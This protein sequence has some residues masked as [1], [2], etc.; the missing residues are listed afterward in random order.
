MGPVAASAAPNIW[1]RKWLITRVAILKTEP[2]MPSPRV[3]GRDDFSV[4]LGTRRSLRRGRRC[5]A[6]E[7]GEEARARLRQMQVARLEHAAGE[8]VASEAEGIGDLV[9]PRRPAGV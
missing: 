1:T 9:R 7:E 4:K 3:C 2:Q 6:A 8:E 5:G